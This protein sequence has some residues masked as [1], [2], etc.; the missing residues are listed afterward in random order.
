VI[1]RGT[2]SLNTSETERVNINNVPGIRLTDPL[3][4]ARNNDMNQQPNFPTSSRGL[5]R[6]MRNDDM[7][8]QPYFPTNPVRIGRNNDIN[9]QPNLP[10]SSRGLLRNVRNND[11]NEQSYFPT[12]PLQSRRSDIMN[13]QRTLPTSSI[14]NIAGEQRT[15]PTSSIGNIAGNRPSNE[16]IIASEN[17]LNSARQ[18][19]NATRQREILLGNELRRRSRATDIL[20]NATVATLASNSLGVNNPGQLPHTPN[21]ELRS[22]LTNFDFTSPLRLAPSDQPDRTGAY[23]MHLTPRRQRRA[24]ITGSPAP[25]APS[26]AATRRRSMSV[27]AEGKGASVTVTEAEDRFG[28]MANLECKICMDKVVECAIRPCGH[29]CACY[30]CA[31]HLQFS[32][33]RCP[34]CRGVIAEAIRIYW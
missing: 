3:R 8:E 6:N 15:L 16:E 7:N 32:L 2:F 12:N 22:T 34:I 1:N 27:S 17:R 5:H 13:E 20:P 18:N 31:R 28:K 25:L 33:G 19:F 10:T 30:E 4:N 9:E 29:A 14:G 21:L 26:A 24:S 23:R 11:I